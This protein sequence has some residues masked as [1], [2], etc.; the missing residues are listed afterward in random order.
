MNR[1]YSA[2]EQQTLSSEDNPPSVVTPPILARSL[3]H[4]N[5]SA[6]CSDVLHV[7]SRRRCYLQLSADSTSLQAFPSSSLP[8][9]IQ[10]TPPGA[11]SSLDLHALGSKHATHSIGDRRPMHICCS[12]VRVPGAVGRAVRRS[13][14]LQRVAR[15]LDHFATDMGVGCHIKALAFAW[16]PRC[17]FFDST[18]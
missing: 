17:G 4:A 15:S 12:F 6:I 16:A 3:A 14:I 8:F 7:V 2:C 1:K 9:V 18:N 11:P 13:T 10:Q 5:T